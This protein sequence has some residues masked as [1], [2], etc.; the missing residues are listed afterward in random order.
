LF[1]VVAREAGTYQFNFVILPMVLRDMKK[2]GNLNDDDIQLLI[3][4]TSDDRAKVRET[5]WYAIK[6][7]ALADAP[8]LEAATLRALKE[9]TNSY[10][11]ELALGVLCN[12]GPKPEVIRAV[13]EAVMDD[14]DVVIQVRA[15][16]ALAGLT[17][18]AGF[19]KDLQAQSVEDVL[20]L[21]HKYATGCDRP[22]KD[23]GWREVGNALCALGQDGSKSLERIM[24]EK[25]DARLAELAWKVI[26]LKQEDR[27]CFV[28]EDQ[29]R[30]AHTKHPFLKLQ[31]APP[32]K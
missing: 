3:Q 16:T 14:K 29:D 7:I 6:G 25:Q 28:T 26:Y 30:I 13:R 19:P 5:A 2:S 17:R 27:F 20:K 31:A 15:A 32:G 11:R 22:D 23:W 8:N 21:F 12:V 1:D 10:A 24:E 4:K 9:D 18:S